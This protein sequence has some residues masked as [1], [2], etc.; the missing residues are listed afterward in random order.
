MTVD[1]YINKSQNNVLSKNIALIKNVACR[2]Y[3]TINVINPSLIIDYDI[4]LLSCNYVYIPDF[5]RYYFAVINV[6][7]DNS[8]TLS[9]NVD[10]LMSFQQSILNSYATVL[11]NS[12]IG[13]PT[14]VVDAKFPIS[15]QQTFL[16]ELNFPL[17]P[18]VRN[19]SLDDR[20]ILLEVRN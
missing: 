9:C 20:H 8:I 2:P 5:N 7:T 13:K 14:Y 10:V 16:H 3:D 6:N 4:S 12:G 17:Q 1:L 19:V 11:R 15:T 18:Y